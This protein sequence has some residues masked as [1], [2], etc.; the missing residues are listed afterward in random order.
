MILSIIATRF[1]LAKGTRQASLE[2]IEYTELSTAQDLFRLPEV[3]VTNSRH[4]SV[5]SYQRSS[6]NDV[7]HGALWKVMKKKVLFFFSFLP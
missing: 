6:I 5:A 2:S 7:I 4:V 1:V 3:S